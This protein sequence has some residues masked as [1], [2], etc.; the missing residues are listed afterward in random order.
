MAVHSY[1]PPVG[2]SSRREKDDD[3]GE[4]E[5][6]NIT[7]S[8]NGGFTVNCHHRPK[9]KSGKAK[10]IGCCYVP[11]KPYTFESFESMSKFLS[12]KLGGGQAADAGGDKS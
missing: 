12:A 7:P 5:Y 4:L 2:Q 6:I 3:V 10:E 9:P 1:N 8:E 11:P